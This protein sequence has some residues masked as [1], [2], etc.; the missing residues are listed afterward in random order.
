MN[1]PIKRLA[2]R[3]AAVQSFIHSRGGFDA[4]FAARAEAPPEVAEM[5]VKWEAHRK[6]CCKCGASTQMGE[7]RHVR[8]G[9][10]GGMRPMLAE[11]KL[12]C[13]RCQPEPVSAPVGRPRLAGIK[14]R[15]SWARRLKPHAVNLKSQILNLK[16]SMKPI[17]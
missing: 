10:G 15:E 1:D 7:L 5:L 14:R 12:I 4:A 16:S 13:I 6:P 3:I 9:Q 17:L 8:R 11:D 2:R